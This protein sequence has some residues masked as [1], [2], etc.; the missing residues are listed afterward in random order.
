MLE[1]LGI[2]DLSQ[3]VADMS[4]AWPV[5]LI[6]ILLCMVITFIYTALLKNFAEI[7]SWASI[8]LVLVGIFALG[9]FVNDYANTHYS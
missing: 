7:L 8:I 9:Y 5:Y 3:H 2:N 1:K 4:T 6:A